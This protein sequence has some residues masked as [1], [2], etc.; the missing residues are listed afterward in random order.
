MNLKQKKAWLDRVYYELGNQF[1][2]HVCGTYEK[3]GE[4][5][6]TKWKTF[7]EAIFPIDFDGTCKDWKKESY[8]KQINQRQILPNELVLDVEEPERIQEIVDKLK[9]LSF[10]SFT[11]WHT[12]SRGFHIHIFSSK[13]VKEKTRETIKTF[14]VNEFGTDVQKCSEK[15]LIA[16][17]DCPHWKTGKLKTNVTEEFL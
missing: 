9:T 16:L 6:F 4:R 12:G 17:E 13:P 3:N 2:F 10:D 1:D 15:N 14:I 8:F 11:V 5:L 7:H